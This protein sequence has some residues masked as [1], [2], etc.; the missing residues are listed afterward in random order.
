V[1]TSGE[2]I[3]V[4]VALKGVSKTLD[5]SLVTEMKKASGNPPNEKKPVCWNCRYL[6]WM[7]GIGLGAR[8]SHRQHNLDL[9]AGLP[10]LIPSRWHR[11]GH[12]EERKS[13]LQN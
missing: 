5:A 4:H 12:Y 2:T 6:A 1:N 3:G 10:V 9:S 7:V 8:C 11:C 13:H